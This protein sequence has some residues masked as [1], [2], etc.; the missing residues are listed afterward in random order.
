MQEIYGT[1]CATLLLALGLPWERMVQCLMG[2][3]DL[4]YDDAAE[5]LLTA[6]SMQSRDDDSAKRRVL[7]ARGARP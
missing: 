7:V 2:D 1:R 3:L 4:S 6:Q 5:A